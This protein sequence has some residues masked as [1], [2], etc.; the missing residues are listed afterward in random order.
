[1]NNLTHNQRSKKKLTSYINE[2]YPLLK[3]LKIKIT[4]YRLGFGEQTL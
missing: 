4:D 3:N 1:M 2:K